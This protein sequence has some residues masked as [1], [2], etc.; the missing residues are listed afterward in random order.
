MESKDKN[1]YLD[2]MVIA[3]QLF[4]DAQERLRRHEELEANEPEAKAALD[5]ALAAHPVIE[6][7]YRIERR[8]LLPGQCCDKWGYRD[9]AAIARLRGPFDKKRVLGELVDK[10]AEKFP[11]RFQAYFVALFR[12]AVIPPQEKFDVLCN[13]LDE[14]AE[15]IPD[16]SVSR[17]DIN[18]MYSLLK[19]APDNIKAALE[20]E[21]KVVPPNLWKNPPVS[22]I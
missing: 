7:V 10:V 8:N 14:V 4:L 21:P 22:L 19:N 5:K 3:Y 15:F 17:K 2:Y 9:E 11:R 1:P 16:V 13:K 18:V 20:W 12:D 6:Q